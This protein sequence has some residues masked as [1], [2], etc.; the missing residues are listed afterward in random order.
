LDNVDAQ[1]YVIDPLLAR[2][3][4]VLGGRIAD[5]AAPIDPRT[6]LNHDFPEHQLDECLVAERLERGAALPR[7]GERFRTA[8]V[9]RAAFARLGPVDVG[10]RRVAWQQ[11]FERAS[12]QRPARRGD[13]EARGRRD[14]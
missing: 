3:G 12:Q 6:H 4:I 7:Q 5:L 8:L 10:D 1:G 13:T 11:A 9:R 2:H 14:Q